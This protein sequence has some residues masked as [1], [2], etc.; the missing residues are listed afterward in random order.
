MLLLLIGTNAFSQSRL[1]SLFNKINPQKWSAS[2]EKKMNKLEDKIVAKSEKT[3]HRLQR[4]EEKIYPK[5]L[6]TKD[7]V[8]AKTK[9]AEAESKY[10]ALEDRLRSPQSSLPNTARQYIPHLDTLTTA[11]K[12]L[13]QNKMTASVKD[14][15]SKIEGLNNRL[16][17]AEEIKKFIHDRKEQLKNE[18]QQLGME[19][20]LKKYNKEVYYYSE[21]IKEYK[22]ILNDP[23]KIEKKA[24]ELL[25]KTKFFQDFLRK[26]SLLASLFRLP[27]NDPTDPAYQANLAG[28]QTRA[29]VNNIIQQQISTGGPNAMQQFQ[30][31]MQQA[32]SQIQQLKNKILQS[33]GSSSDDEMPDLPDGKAGFKPNNQKTKSFLKRLEWGT[34]FQT[35]RAT[36]Y[37]PVTSDIGL[38]VGYKL[39]DKSVIGIGASYK[40]GWGTGWK[41]ISITQQGAGL[42]SYLDWK[43]P[44]GSPKG[45]MFANLWI[46]GGF[47]M[48]YKT[49]FN[50]IAQLQ[51]FNAFQQSGLIGLSKI[52]SLHSPKGGAG[53]G[54]FKKTKVQVLW[55][56]LSYEQVPRTQPVVFRIGYCIK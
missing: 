43:A 12:F 52:V 39:N 7:S 25:S 34:N 30:Q 37:F 48:N 1:D 19:K 23:D 13:D 33:G 10:K 20:E 26:N 46:S 53:G 55:D 40:L 38:S 49:L 16:D 9:L 4:Q 32:Q 8:V 51:D 28:L 5:Q 35:Q 36:N 50:S 18:L 29:Q 14:A 31:N 27:S 42:R 6:R 2:V 3:L 11:F 15:L 56:F 21:Q 24:I 47:E 41:N 54:L 22:T 44:F 17:Q 45:G